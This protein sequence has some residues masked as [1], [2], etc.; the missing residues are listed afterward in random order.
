MDEDNLECLHALFVTNPLDD[1]SRIQSTKDTLLEGSCSWIFGDLTY[2]RWLNDRQSRPL[3]IH[4]DPGKGKTMLTIAVTA[5]L[6]TR[7]E[8]SDSS[9]SILA[10]FFCDDKDD[11]TNNA[12]AILRG[13]LYQILCQQP[14]LFG[15]LKNEYKKQKTKLFESRN[16]F[17]TLWRILQS[18]LLES[19]LEKV[20]LI[21]DALDECDYDSRTVLLRLIEKD[22]NEKMAETIPGPT[23]K[24]MLIS[25]NDAD[26]KEALFHSLDIS[27]ELNSNQVDVAVSKFIDLKVE[28]LK[29]KKGYSETLKVYVRD[30]LR[31]KAEGTFLWVSLACAELEKARA[32]EGIMRNA[33]DRLPRGLEGI[34]T[35]IL[36][37][38]LTNDQA[39]T[40][41]TTKEILKAVSIAMRPL[42]LYELACIAEIPKE[43]WN[44]RNVLSE[45]VS[46]CGSL[47]TIRG[48]PN[49]KDQSSEHVISRHATVHLVHQSAKD[50]LTSQYS[51]L[52]L[53]PD[54]AEEHATVVRRSLSYIC[55]G[56]FA[57]GPI[58]DSS[59][60]DIDSES[61]D[62]QDNASPER[63]GLE[64]LDVKVGDADVANIATQEHD[65][66]LQ[67][68]LFL[69]YP[70]IYWVSH[71]REAN[72]TIGDV[73][74]VHRDFFEP[75]S[76]I[77]DFWIRS[78]N[79][80]SQS[81]VFPHELH[82]FTLLHFGACTG[83]YSLAKR[84]LD[85]IHVSY[86]SKS[87][88]LIDTKDQHGFTA[89]IY[90]AKYGHKRV[91][92]LLLER[93][94]HAEERDWWGKTV[95]MY[96]AELENPAISL[97]LLNHGASVHPKDQ[98]GDTALS[99]ASKKGQ[100]TVVKLLLQ[101]G[102]NDQSSN[103]SMDRALEVAAEAGHLAVV[104]LLLKE[105]AFMDRDN[106]SLRIPLINA[107][108]PGHSAVVEVLL[109]HGV[110]VGEQDDVYDVAL[111]AAFARQ[112]KTVELLL[113]HGA[114]VDAVDEYRSTTLIKAA[115]VGNDA[116]V[117][118]L[119][120]HGANVRASDNFGRTALMNAAEDGYDIVVELLL[121]HGVNVNTSSKFGDTTL[122]KAIMHGHD[123]V[124]ELLL[125]HGANVNASDT[126][127]DTA[128][129]K[130]ILRGHNK[131]VEL[132][133]QFE[134]NLE[135]S[136]RAADTAL[137]Y[138]A[139]SDH[140]AITQLL[141]EKGAHV[142][143]RNLKGNSPLADAASRGHSSIVELLL[144]HD[145][146][147]DSADR[148]G[149]SVL[150]L[151]AIEGC[152]DVCRILLKNGATLKML[153][154]EDDDAISAFCWA[155]LKCNEKMAK[156]CLTFYPKMS[157][158]LSDCLVPAAR[159][160]Y[161]ASIKVLLEHKVTI[162]TEI[163]EKDMAGF[164]ATIEFDRLAFD[165]YTPNSRK[166]VM[167]DFEA[168]IDSQHKALLLILQHR[169]ERLEDEKK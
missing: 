73:F 105:R 59:D 121:K 135:A 104:Q 150:S 138:A 137:N 68:P 63:S 152:E 112:E 115:A 127:G 102:A 42:T 3:W 161:E 141:L 129:M 113:R 57:N 53:L 7:L 101:Q 39:Y 140:E 88:S 82:N 162:N 71:G 50:F 78:Y 75:E 55:S 99:C 126:Y 87:D 159:R 164:Y 10:Y 48:I 4:G 77:R 143:R 66:D 133:L 106:S 169:K 109:R 19:K 124:V 165:P 123:T 45:Y 100:E 85:W 157:R 70:I 60:S 136:D 111:A 14:N 36:E 17:Q 8:H 95:L 142:N 92:E 72:S 81:Y 110:R 1:M 149:C 139:I 74:D 62:A 96:S 9:N 80:I 37:K 116:A 41:D 51:H 16:A 69:E 21:V 79:V 89:L 46:Q 144:R 154:R 155:S 61:S 27:L 28:Q 5:E 98:Y 91:V 97:V 33:L 167:K 108:R 24:W 23:L 26:I 64:H 90:A 132:L 54:L 131:A 31:N 158:F 103:D 120:K 34:Y 93:G 44:D 166:A 83:I 25:R 22:S 30:T 32:V 40:A 18:M 94:A 52:L 76:P 86:T 67:P 163:K 29:K 58:H 20:Y 156:E 56:I 128:L 12:V 107:A 168:L 35:Q 38:A 146:D 2:T 145:A 148:T 84:I 114:N 147:V 11:R 118:L 125:K 43:C 6:S 151:A 130:A 117:K 47:L 15:H 13:L 122:M 160:G 119:L 153:N 49:V 65:D 134:A